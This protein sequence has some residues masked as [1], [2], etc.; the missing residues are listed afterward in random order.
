MKYGIQTIAD[1][2]GILWLNEQH[3]EEGLDH[4]I[5]QVTIVKYHSDHRKHRNELVDEQK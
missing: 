2:Y 1:S 5:L 3:M 4:K